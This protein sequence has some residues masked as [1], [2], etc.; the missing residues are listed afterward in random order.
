MSSQ[1]LIFLA[2][3]ACA[4]VS[5]LMSGMEAG[6]LALSPLRIRQLKRAGNKRAELLLGYLQRPENFLW[7]ILIG[8]TIANF[9]VISS[10][11]I[12]LLK[13]L[14]GP[15]LLRI[16]SFV[17]FAFLFYVFCEL[18]P[19]MLFRIYPNRLCLVLVGPFRII[20][21]ILMPIVALVAWFS[22]WLLR[23]T[24]GK[25]FTGN[26]F[27]GRDELRFLVQESAQALTSEEKAMINR[28][29]DLQSLTLR[30]ITIPLAQATA[31]NVQTPMH[32]VLRLGR[33][34]GR[35]R[36]PVWKMEG[37]RQRV[38]GIVSLKTLLY[39]PE[40]DPEKPAGNYI[41]PAL[42]LNEGLRLEDALHRLRRSGQRIA[43][44]LGRDHREIGIVTLQDILKTI[45]GE[46]SL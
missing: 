13:S 8:N 26:I 41:K 11:V 38:L 27:G 16:G 2:I 35:T 20:H 4:G 19:K 31:V 28:V 33:D 14:P 45:F 10:V 6:V 22:R 40:L 42:Y 17:L 3:L 39:S 43:I 34:T 23:W 46:V 18:L 37:G 24:G 15:V 21:F 44:V 30:H 7:T 29:L 32:E 1:I 36:F 25:R 5:F 9:A 12:I